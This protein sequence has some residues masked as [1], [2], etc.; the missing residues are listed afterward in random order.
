MV[1][2]DPKTGK[3][4]LLVLGVSLGLNL[5]VGGFLIG[6]ELQEHRRP[7]HGDGERPRA[8]NDRMVFGFVD[9]LA[10]ALP[11]DDRKEFKSVMETYRGEL[12]AAATRVRQARQK[13]RSA[14]GADNFDRSALE[15]ALAEVGSGMQDMQKVLHGAMADAVSHLS[16]EARKALANWEPRDRDRDRDKDRDGDRDHAPDKDGGA[17]P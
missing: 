10:G 6:D 1:T 12:T 4:L 5:F 15:S 16:P 2:L 11:K 7:P 3:W 9:R 8:D 13:V 14:I 17:K